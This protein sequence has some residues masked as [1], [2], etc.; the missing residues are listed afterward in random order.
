LETPLTFG[1]SPGLKS[2][3]WHPAHEPRSVGVRHTAASVLVEWHPD[4]VHVNAARWSP[5][6]SV[7]VCRKVKGVQ[8]VVEWQITHSRDVVMC[9]VDLPV[10]TVLLWHELHPVVMPVWLK[11]AGLHASV[12]WQASHDC[13]VGRWLFGLPVAP[14]PLWQL[15]QVPAT[16][17]RW[18]NWAGVQATVVWQVLQVLSE[19]MWPCDLPRAVDPLWHEK[20][21]PVT[22][23]WSTRVAGCHAVLTWQVSHAFVVVMCEAVLPETCVLL[24]QEKHD[25]DVLVWS[26][27]PTTQVEVVWQASHP[28]VVV[29][30]FV[31]LPVISAPEFVRTAPLWQLAHAPST[32]EWSTVSAGIQDETVWQLSHATV[33]WMWLSPLPDA[34]TPWQVAQLPMNELWSGRP[35]VAQESGEWQ[36]SQVFELWTCVGDLPVIKTPAEVRVVPL[37]HVK[38]LPSTCAWS[39]LVVGVH[40]PVVWQ[41]SQ[42]TVDRIWVVPLPSINVPD[43]VLTVP[44]WQVL[45]VPTTCVW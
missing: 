41:V 27:L 24:W 26:K 29:M 21:V 30:W 4:A 25:S 32:W 35:L 23:V 11:V 38:Q 28:R 6:Y 3:E 16:T 15:P 18:S 37:W 36:F 8:A 42:A 39:T 40:D 44:L 45:H 31:P 17:L 10:V 43:D 12:T 14:T 2:P 33:D 34:D 9:R 1:C 20:Q 7:D 19:A 22:W 13:V 5:G